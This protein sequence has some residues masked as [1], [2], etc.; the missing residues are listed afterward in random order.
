[1]PRKPLDKLID[2]IYDA[3]VEPQLWDREPIELH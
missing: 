2:E 1:M 3:A